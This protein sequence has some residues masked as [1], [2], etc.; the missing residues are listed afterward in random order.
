LFAEGRDGGDKK[1]FALLE[2][3]VHSDVLTESNP[4]TLPNMNYVLLTANLLISLEPIFC[5]PVKLSNK[6]SWP[7]RLLTPDLEPFRAIA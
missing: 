3:N 5:T 4:Q 6:L 2:R 1:R 7:E